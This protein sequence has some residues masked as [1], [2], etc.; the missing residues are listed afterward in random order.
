MCVFVCAHP[1]AD[2]SNRKHALP[3]FPGLSTQSFIGSASR[4]S[5]RTTTTTASSVLPPRTCKRSCCLLRYQQRVSETFVVDDEM[6]SYGKTLFATHA[7]TTRN[8]PVSLMDIIAIHPSIHTH[9]VDPI[10]YHFIHP[11][12]CI[13]EGAVE[14]VLVTYD[15]ANAEKAK[16][17]GLKVRAH[18][19]PL[20]CV[21]IID[22]CGDW[23]QWHVW[24]RRA[25]CA[26]CLSPPTVELPSFSPFQTQY[27]AN[28]PAP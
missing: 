2:L 21:V 11:Y 16:A 12:I 22:L 17:E 9:V 23:C 18:T 7:R 27:N 14:V 8:P 24:Y 20:T 3:L 5:R 25:G 19:C 28:R 13:G 6:C 15:R 4:T 26:M 1:P 10:H